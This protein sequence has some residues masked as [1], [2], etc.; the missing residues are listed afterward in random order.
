MGSRHRRR[1][2][3]PPTYP[4]FGSGVSCRVEHEVGIA[5]AARRDRA[6]GPAHQ[7][8]RTPA[9]RGRQMR[10]RLEDQPAAV[11][12]GVLCP[13]QRRASTVGAAA[14]QHAYG[15][16]CARAAD[17]A[18]VA[19]LP[20]R[21]LGRRV[22]MDL[23]DL[24]HAAIVAAKASARSSEK[25]RT[26]R[27]PP[28]RCERLKRASSRSEGICRAKSTR[29]CSSRQWRQ[30]G[31]HG[32]RSANRRRRSARLP[33]SGQRADIPCCASGTA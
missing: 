21:R 23:D 12:A 24:V 9:Q 11:E 28:L 15:T 1:V 30:C 25:H 31:A 17:A 13:H 20:Q 10:P 14:D 6:A 2:F 3:M 4:T 22:D 32:R 27:P 18:A 5:A 8:R 26:S 19:R 29:C 7:P 33:S 16:R